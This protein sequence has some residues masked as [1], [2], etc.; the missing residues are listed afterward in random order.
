MEIPSKVSGCKYQSQVYEAFSHLIADP[1][2]RGIG[3]TVAD[4]RKT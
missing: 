2:I 4:F 1:N 3:C